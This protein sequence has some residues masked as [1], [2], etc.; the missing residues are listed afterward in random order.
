MVDRPC[1][2]VATSCPVAQTGFQPRR[3]QPGAD[4]PQII[5]EFSKDLAFELYTIVPEPATFALAG[6]RPGGRSSPRLSSA[7]ARL[8]M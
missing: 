8:T 2:W 4:G 6:H 3:Y 1:R 7:I 5:I